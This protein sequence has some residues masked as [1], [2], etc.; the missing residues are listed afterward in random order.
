MT[1]REHARDD[2]AWIEAMTD[3][4]CMEVFWLYVDQPESFLAK[5]PPQLLGAA[6][7]RALREI[8]RLPAGTR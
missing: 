5:Y 6:M 7:R 8:A 1:V 3:A 2:D 4:E